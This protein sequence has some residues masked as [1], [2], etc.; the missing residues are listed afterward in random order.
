MTPDNP[1]SLAVVIPA[2]NEGG[3]IRALV[4]EVRQTVPAQVVVCD[5]G[6][7]GGSAHASQC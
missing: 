2:L 3:N 7:S 4:L 5:N 6:S 1:F